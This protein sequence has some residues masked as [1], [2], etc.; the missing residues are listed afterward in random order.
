MNPPRSFW[1]ISFLILAWMLLG[2]V[3]WIS[4]LMIDEAALAA[5]PVDQRTYVET[6]P[7]WLNWLNTLAEWTGLAGAI[8]LLLRKAWAV[9]ALLVSAVCLLMQFA[10]GLVATDGLALVGP[11]Y[12]AVIP[13]IILSISTACWWYAHRAKKRGWIG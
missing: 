8:A 9:P 6:Y 7:G 5:M 1:I 11:V 12:V 13:A 3:I 2:L 10:G 4:N